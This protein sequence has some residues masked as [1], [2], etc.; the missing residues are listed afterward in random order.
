MPT[1]A[2]HP[3]AWHK[4]EA[5]CRALF[6]VASGERDAPKTFACSG[7]AAW[8]WR[9]T[10]GEKFLKVFVPRHRHPSFIFFPPARQ[11]FLS[12]PSRSGVFDNFCSLRGHGRNTH[13]KK[14]ACTRGRTSFVLRGSGMCGPLLFVRAFA[15]PAFPRNPHAG[16]RGRGCLRQRIAYARV[17]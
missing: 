12:R 5:V 9:G 8:P 3:S 10:K 15:P 11:K 17:G 4:V 6:F 1:R 2:C 7:T 14:S 13:T 16:R